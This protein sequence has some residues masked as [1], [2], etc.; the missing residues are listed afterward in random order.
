[1][2]QEIEGLKDKTSPAIKRLVDNLFPE[3]EKP[4][5]DASK[6]DRAYLDS[7][8]AL[9]SKKIQEV[10]EKLNAIDQKALST[11][12]QITTA[13]DVNDIKSSIFSGLIIAVIAGGATFGL[14]Q[15]IAR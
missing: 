3:D 4:A 10:S 13:K 15:L 7:Q 8:V 1:M 2:E 6:D 9:L 5:T 14:M 12:L 11:L